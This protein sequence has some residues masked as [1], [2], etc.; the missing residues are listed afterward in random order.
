[1]R[2]ILGTGILFA[3]MQLLFGE[4][5]R[6]WRLELFGENYPGLLVAIL[7]PGAFIVAGFLIALKNAIDNAVEKRRLAAQPKT[8][9]KGARRVRTTGAIG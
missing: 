3:D 1:V 9:V 5:A 2:E 4:G 6:T 8:I 7:P